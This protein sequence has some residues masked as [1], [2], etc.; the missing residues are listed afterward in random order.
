MGPGPLC[1][2]LVKNDSVDAE[3]LLHKIMLKGSL[4][5]G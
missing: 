1:G 5:E 3:C 4:L 2:A